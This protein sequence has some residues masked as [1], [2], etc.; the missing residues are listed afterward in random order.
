[1]S[2]HNRKLFYILPVVPLLFTGCATKLSVDSEPQG[3]T[4]LWS[5]TG[6]DDWRSWPPNTWDSKSEDQAITPFSDSA[7]YSDS[8]WITVEKE[9]YYRPLPVV[10]EL[11]ANRSEDLFFELEETPEARIAKLIEEGYVLYRGEYV[12]PNEY[13]LEEVDGV[14]MNAEEAF[15]AR[16]RKKGFVEYDGQWMSPEEAQRQYAANQQAQGFISFKDRWVKPEVKELEESIDSE[17]STIANTDEFMDLRL[18]RV[19]GSIDMDLAQLQIHNSSRFQIRVLLSGPRS[20][21]LILSPYETYGGGSVGTTLQERLTLL[22]GEYSIAVV[23]ELSEAEKQQ[24]AVAG[25]S[26]EGIQSNLNSAY[27]EHPFS[28][29]YQ[30]LLTY[31]PDNSSLEQGLSEY[32]RREVILPDDLPEIE[33]PEVD[34]PQNE[35]R[36]GRNGNRS[37]GED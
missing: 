21:S 14:W 37:R 19:V 13:D 2:Y 28:P 15:I 22:P 24:A 16:Q 31:N 1:M 34:L 18:P 33:V 7:T 8:I 23:P 35:Q 26:I 20:Q 29:G 4:V 11:M 10:A 9:G 27:T 12:L 17:V 32:E 30:Y 25:A 3:A 5:P 36:R 6:V